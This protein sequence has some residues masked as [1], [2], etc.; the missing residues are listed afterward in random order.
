MKNLILTICI[1]ITLNIFS[2]EGWTKQT[3]YNLEKNIKGDE[4]LIKGNLVISF[5]TDSKLTMYYFDKSIHC[6]LFTMTPFTE[7]YTN[8]YK[9]MLNK[10]GKLLESNKWRFEGSNCYFIVTYEETTAGVKSFVWEM[11]L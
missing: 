4:E 6:K 7:E 8:S 5:V 9:S 11:I 2:Q 1:S 3:V 10:N